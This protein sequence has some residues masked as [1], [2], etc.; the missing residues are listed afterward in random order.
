M[1][2]ASYV[3][4]TH[5]KA[6]KML[7]VNEDSVARTT[8][9]DPKLSVLRQQM[10]EIVAQTVQ[11]IAKDNFERMERGKSDI[12]QW[13]KG[14]YYPNSYYKMLVEAAK[15]KESAKQRLDFF[16]ERNFFYHP[17][18]PHSFVLVPSLTFHSG[19]ALAQII[20][21]AGI[22]PSEAIEN[23]VEKQ[24]FGLLDCGMVC[25]IGHYYAL[26]KT[27]GKE[28]FDKLFSHGNAKPMKISDYNQPDNP[29]LTFLAVMHP[30]KSEAG[31]RIVAVGQKVNF[32]NAKL[33]KMKHNLMG[34]ASNYNVICL[35]ARP[36]QQ[37]FVG[38]GANPNGANERDM[39][40]LLLDEYN[41]PPLSCE[42][43]SQSL[44]QR[45]VPEGAE[46]N[47]AKCDFIGQPTRAN[48]KN[49]RKCLGKMSFEEKEER[50]AKYRAWSQPVTR[51]QI[52]DPDF[53]YGEELVIDF[54]VGLIDMLMRTPLEQISMDFV[55]QS[56]DT[57]HSGFIEEELPI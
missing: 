52:Q 32:Q 3:V 47:K 22:L 18:P 26:Y 20:L 48:E 5:Q 14:I 23:V 51:N 46:C 9:D 2:A 29:L 1:L 19:F 43:L 35:D 39:E 38:L 21:K 57:C 28:K 55:Q 30:I 33:Y 8:P 44:I 53:G 49:L 4:P 10:G 25:Q 12:A 11:K 27:L 37:A 7:E 40:Q 41:A 34:E 50:I 54:N 6:Y 42:P 56:R 24:E 45:I 17:F 16:R 15:T 13:T 36:D 31:K